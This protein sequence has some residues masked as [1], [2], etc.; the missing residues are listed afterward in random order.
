MCV[1]DVKDSGWLRQKSFY[2]KLSFNFSKNLSTKFNLYAPP[3]I[4]MQRP[5][6]LARHCHGGQSSSS[7]GPGWTRHL[8]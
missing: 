5:Q 7:G 2:Q 1:R 8:L 6:G 3:N 4:R